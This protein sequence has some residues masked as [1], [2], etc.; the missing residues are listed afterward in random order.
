[1]HNNSKYFF[2]KDTSA[3][4]AKRKSNSVTFAKAKIIN[5]DNIG[6]IISKIMINRRLLDVTAKQDQKYEIYVSIPINNDKLRYTTHLRYVV[7]IAI[8]FRLLAVEYFTV[9]G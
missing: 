9:I 7:R 6:M 3:D 5:D 4:N 8:L 1:M 2:Q